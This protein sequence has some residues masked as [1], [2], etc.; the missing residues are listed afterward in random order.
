MEK[1]S[2]GPMCKPIQ[3]YAKRLRAITFAIV[4]LKSDNYMGSNKEI[5]I[6]FFAFLVHQ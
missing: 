5:P 1:I 2:Y 4:K 3:Q 6:D